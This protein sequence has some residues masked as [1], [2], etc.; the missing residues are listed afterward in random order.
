MKDLNG[1]E[2]KNYSTNNHQHID[3]GKRLE[4]G[5]NSGTVSWESLEAS[6]WMRPRLL[7][8]K[9]RYG[10]GIDSSDGHR[11]KITVVPWSGDYFD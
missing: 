9:Q 10:H 7:S 5:I 6:P 2:H 11:M 3:R 1:E 4:W 8:C